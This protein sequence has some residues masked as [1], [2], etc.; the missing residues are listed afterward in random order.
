MTKIKEF[1]GKLKETKVSIVAIMVAILMF[2][3]GGVIGAGATFAMTHHGEFG[4][5]EY[6]M[7]G[8]EEKRQERRGNEEHQGKNEHSKDGKDAVKQEK[9]QETKDDA[10]TTTSTDKKETTTSSSNN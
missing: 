9:D 8:S 2:V 7:K 5:G 3:A 10:K 4:H 1:F 6:R